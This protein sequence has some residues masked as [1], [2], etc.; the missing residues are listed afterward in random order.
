[1]GDLGRQDLEVDDD[2]TFEL[3]IS[4][5]RPERGNWLELPAEAR[6]LQIR[7]YFADWDAHRP[8]S[9]AIERTDSPATA[10]SP[11]VA[12]EDL[13]GSLRNVVG[14]VHDYLL[15]H[16]EMIE[17]RYPADPNTMSVP[18]GAAAGNRNISYSMGKFSLAPD[19]AL[20]LELDELRSRLWTV[21]WLTSPW[22]SNPD[23]ANRVTSVV[24]RHAPVDSDGKLRVVVAPT[25]PATPN[26][27]DVA[28]H[29]RGA[30]VARWI[31]GT[32][33]PIA[34]RVVPLSSVRSALPADT[35][36]TTAAER[37]AEISM[38]RANLAAR[39]R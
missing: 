32:A 25:D 34:T 30:I 2:G 28:G 16:K 39:R 6:M 18:S 24:S 35:P 5:E 33:N 1:V 10:P 31:W 7:E 3:V 23:M 4:R 27:L 21:Q 38:R 12:P 36:V 14:Y 20:V 19:E 8:G 22:Y 37:G 29:R 11:T 13:A 15:T 9:F 17:R 26:W